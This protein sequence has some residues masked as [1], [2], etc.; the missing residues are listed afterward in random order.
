MKRRAFLCALGA[1]ACS[2]S[3][4]PHPLLRGALAAARDAGALLAS[5]SSF[6]ESELAR[7]AELARTHLKGTPPEAAARVLSDL[8]FVHLGFVREVENTSLEFVLL[9]SVLRRRRGSCVGLGMLL[10]VLAEALE[11]KASGVLMPGHFY[12]RLA[13]GER[14]RNVELLRRGE[15]MPDAWYAQRFPIPDGSAGEYARPLSSQEALGVIDFDVGN[16]R[17]RQLRLEEARA[18]YA[19]AVHAFPVFAEAHASLGTTLH[20]LGRLDEARESYDRARSL[21][22]KLRG[23]AGNYALLDEERAAR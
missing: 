2:P 6:S 20:L 21:N 9:P 14:F 1:A 15:S 16:E 19:R 11:L 17:H 12:V 8:L 3:R 18:A 13:A 5:D 10:L 4:A 7:M 23:I 22:P